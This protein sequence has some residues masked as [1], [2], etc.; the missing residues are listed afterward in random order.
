MSFLRKLFGLGRMNKDVD[1]RE[2]PEGEFIDAN[3]I[4]ITSGE[5]GNFSAVKNCLSNK[6]LLILILVLMFILLED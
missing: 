1:P 4:L 3:N 5:D 6:K 2:L